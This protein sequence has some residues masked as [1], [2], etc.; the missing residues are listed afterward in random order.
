MDRRE[1]PAVRAALPA[2]VAGGPREVARQAREGRRLTPLPSP[3]VAAR[4]RSAQPARAGVVTSGWLAEHHAGADHDTPVAVARTGS[5][6]SARTSGRSSASL[7]TRRTSSSRPRGRWARRPGSRRAAAPRAARAP[8]R[9]RR[10]RRP[11]AP[12]RRGR[13]AARWR[14]PPARTRSASRTTGRRAISSTHA[15]ALRRHAL[16]VHLAVPGQLREVG[17]GAARARGRHDV[18]PHA[19]V[20]GAVPPPVA[21]GL[22][23]DGIAE[24]L[25]GGRGGRPRPRTRRELGER[26]CRSTRSSAAASSSSARATAAV[27]LARRRRRRRSHQPL[28]RAGR[29]RCASIPRRRRAATSPR[30]A[31][32][33]PRARSAY[34]PRQR[35][36]GALGARRSSAPTRGRACRPRPGTA[37]SAG[38]P[39]AAKNIATTGLSA[40]RTGGRLTQR[41]GRTAL[42]GIAIG[43]TNTRRRSGVRARVDPSRG[44]ARRRRRRR[45]PPGDGGRTD[46]DRIARELQA[47]PAQ[48]VGD[49]HAQRG[50]VADDRDPR[51]G[52]QRLVGE[53]QGGV[54]QLG[55]ASRPG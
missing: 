53:Q 31:A 55:D 44:R 41:L 45:S 15:D 39:S 22:D 9:R 48:R 43:G 24:L 6:A 26:R 14:C 27:D 46:V 50:G 7:P 38:T 8:A 18:E 17:E 32:C 12:G 54:E 42:P 11:A 10:G 35:R 30:R 3:P 37:S 2:R 20:V 36:G 4:H 52:G 34:G 1:G 19:D 40:C 51:P 49:Q 33:A 21:D 29:G 16:D 28:R 25:G 23:R 47:L 13:R 5:S